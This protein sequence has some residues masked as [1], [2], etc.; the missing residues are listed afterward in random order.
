M[1]QLRSL[2]MKLR[3]RPFSG[4]TFGI[5]G[6]RLGDSRGFAERRLSAVSNPESSMLVHCNERQSTLVCFGPDDRVASILGSVLTTPS[7]IV[8]KGESV[9]KI[10]S[11]L[12]KPH[13][14][15]H[16]VLDFIF[17]EQTITINHLEGMAAD[18]YLCHLTRRNRI[19]KLPE[20]HRKYI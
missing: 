19:W 7:G 12:G 11:R 3:E 6:L 13:F 8:K 14:H 9:K 17:Q 18:F 4:A 20:H 10:L 16:Y 2:L 15:D 1:I 5:D